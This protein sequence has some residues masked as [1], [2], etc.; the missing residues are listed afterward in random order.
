MGH[1]RLGRLPRTK[2]WR[3]VVAELET[4][5]ATAA[6]LAA[7][8]F[9][10]ASSYLRRY[11][12]SEEGCY[13]PLL[14]LTRLAVAS[15]SPDTFWRYVRSV[16][17][18]D[19]KKL[20][21]VGLLQ[22]IASGSSNRPPTSDQTVFSDIADQAFRE[23]VLNYVRTG[24]D[25]LWGVS[26]E[27]VRLAFKKVASKAGFS[28]LARQWFGRFVGRSLLYFLDRELP[29]HVGTSGPL[30]T[31]TT[32]VEAERSVLAYA[33]ERTQIIRDFAPGWL[34]K[35][36]WKEGELSLPAARAFYA[37]CIKKITEDIAKEDRE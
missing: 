14:E 10:A 23:T 8:T 25:T 34:S 24:A 4:P 11:S 6:G 28:E 30:G 26:S 7:K 32:A 22:A 5:S 21:G 19:P 27:D 16:G 36:L 15:R 2:A 29:N 18:R 9:S 3:D 17:V 20:D 33:H 13:G 37:Y 1:I 31:S 12:T 35:T